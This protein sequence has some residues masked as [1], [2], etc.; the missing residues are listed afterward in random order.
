MGEPTASAVV[1]GAAGVGL[2]GVMAGVDAAAAVGALFGALIYTTR[3]PEYPTWQR[4]LYLVISFGMG[5]IAA[6]AL[7]E[8]VVMGIRPFQYTGLGA[9][10]SALLCI[11]LSLWALDR[12]RSGPGGFKR[13]GQ[14]G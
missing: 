9:F 8:L 2:A 4:L 6:P 3:T 5:Y 13:G 11:T 7:R 14:D 12:G 1:A 10:V